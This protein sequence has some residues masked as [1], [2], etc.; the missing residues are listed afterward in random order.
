MN[1]HYEA[2]AF[3]ARNVYELNMMRQSLTQQNKQYFVVIL[4]DVDHMAVNDPTCVIG[5]ILL[6][7]LAEYSLLQDAGNKDQFNNAYVHYLIQGEMSEAIDE[8]I[9]IYFSTM[10]VRGVNLIFYVE[11]ADRITS[12]LDPK[13]FFEILFWH[14]QTNYGMYVVPFGSPQISI[15]QRF[16]QRN[17]DRAVAKGLINPQLFMDQPQPQVQPVQ[18]Q[19]QQQQSQPRPLF[20]RM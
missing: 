16:V 6:P 2:Q 9:L 8:M 17:L 11:G 14:F 10:I 4:D 7:G 5:S 1:L 18:P 15:D 3:F 20:A 13:V 19:V 12:S